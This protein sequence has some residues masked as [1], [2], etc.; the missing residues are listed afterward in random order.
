ME[1]SKKF[2]VGDF[3]EENEELA[4]SFGLKQA[5]TLVVVAGGAA[6]KFVGVSDVKKY[7]QTVS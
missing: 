2:E 3:V 6:E 4:K 5:P 7:I 1:S